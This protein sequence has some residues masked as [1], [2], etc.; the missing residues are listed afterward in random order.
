MLSKDGGWDGRRCHLCIL[1]RSHSKSPVS[2][3]KEPIFQKTWGAPVF[4]GA[5]QGT[6]L[7]HLALTASGVCIL[8]SHGAVTNTKISKSHLPEQS[9]EAGD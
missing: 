9:E 8:R 5:T 4:A 3:R 7:D 6:P 1:P 2:F